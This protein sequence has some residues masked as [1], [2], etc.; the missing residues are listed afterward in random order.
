MK[1][2]WENRYFRW[3]VTAFLVIAASMLFY[4]GIFQMKTLMVGVKTVLSIL[5]PILYGVILAYLLSPI[6]DFL[7]KKVIYPLL[8]KKNIQ[9]KKK[10]RKAI[11]YACV[12]VALL[13][14]ISLIYALIMMILPQLIR[15][16][17]NIIYSFPDY[18][19]IIQ[20]WL[21]DLAEHSDKLDQK[22]ISSL[23][24][25]AS[26]AEA[27][28]TTNI[29][30]QLQ[31]MLKNIS[32]GVFDIL[33]FLKNFLIGAIVSIYVMADKEIFVAKSKMIICAL[34][35]IN[36]A[37]AV[38]HAMRLTHRTFGGF[39][40]GKIVDSAII[41]VLC[42]L[43]TTL[44]NMP[45]SILVSVIVGVTN[46]IPFFGP[47]LG[48]IPCILL[49][50][51]TD[52]IQALYFAIFI[53]ILQQF[54]G[55]ILG[56]K[57]LGGSTG[58]SS[59]MVIVAILIGGGLFG[60]P[61]MI[62]GVP[63]L[64]V[65]YALIWGFI[66]RSLHRK[67]LPVEVSDY[68]D[69]DSIHVQ[70]KEP[71][72]LKEK[73]RNFIHTSSESDV[74]AKESNILEVEKI[75][76]ELENPNYIRTDEDEEEILVKSL[77]DVHSSLFSEMFRKYVGLIWAFVTKYAILCWNYIKKYSIIAWKYIRNYWKKFRLWCHTTIESIRNRSK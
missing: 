13:F 56:P 40:N 63:L 59:F 29:L 44:L 15:S 51:L 46:V 8:E 33:N 55:N 16:I 5:A 41:G 54:D 20:D 47:Y 52:P 57:I 26:Q 66:G 75:L 2:G 10:R 6:V 67:E 64:A 68:F 19:K 28:L 27:Y 17:M 22:T 36:K 73:K 69:M 25:Y 48:A 45:Y 34:L 71:I 37:N 50:L 3:G 1:F 24:D 31:K 14:F 49:I 32:E 65:I 77:E 30:P 42:Y 74:V 58:L 38:I 76:T 18:V 35:P 70:T 62:V 72:K 53:L 7:E 23:T 12:L 11:R 39:I 43:G 60:I 4:F 9:L 21:I 61:G